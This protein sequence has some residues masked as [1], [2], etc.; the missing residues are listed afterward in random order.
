M[1]TVPTPFVPT[2]TLRPLRKEDEP[3]IISLLNQQILRAP[4]SRALD[5]KA[6]LANL[7]QPNPPSYYPIRWHRHQCF[8]IWRAGALEGLIDI[9]VGF[10]S[11]SLDLPDYSPL[12]LLRF[13]LLSAEPT[14]V[15]EVVKLLLTAAT[16]FWRQHG[17]GQVKAF[18]LSTCYP[19]FQGGFGAL[20]GD[21]SDQIRVLTTAD[22][23]LA[24]R[25]YVFL[26]PLDQ[27]IEEKLP[28]GGISIVFRGAPTDRHY[29]LYH[30]ANWIGEAR[31]IALQSTSTVGNDATGT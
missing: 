29:Q 19:E 27:P 2:L 5:Q 26:R 25:Y 16:D 12:G 23:T 1:S 28:T 17:V 9:A 4:Y 14:R 8:C 30:H 22:F 10:D 21:W 3:L 15:D 20:P 13:L 18:H 11:D 6:F 7:L 31:L 24:E